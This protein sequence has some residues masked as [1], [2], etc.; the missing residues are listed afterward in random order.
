[1]NYVLLACQLLLAA[2]LLFA[3]GGKL[4]QSEQFLS[5]LRLSHIPRRLLLPLAVCVPSAEAGLSI[6]LVVGPHS[7]LPWVFIGALVLLGIFT[8]WM[9]FIYTQK[10]RI[11][12]GCFGTAS[13]YIGPRSI[14]RNVLLLIVSLGGFLISSRVHNLLLEPSLWM[15]MSTLS[16]GM[17]LLLLQAFRRAKPALLISP[18]EELGSD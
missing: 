15:L 10:L 1:M 14:V 9:I 6:G 18:R 2:I 3:A 17:C 4:L 7:L 13:S 11:K 16:I 8:L 12:C 5:A